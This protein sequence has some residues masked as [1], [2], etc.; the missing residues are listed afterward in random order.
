V[1]S[2]GCIVWADGGVYPFRPLLKPGNWDEMKRW[3]PG[4]KGERQVSST[5]TL[6][7]CREVLELIAGTGMVTPDR[8]PLTAV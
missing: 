2:A 4:F 8:K 1:I 5:A 3:F 6:P 7:W